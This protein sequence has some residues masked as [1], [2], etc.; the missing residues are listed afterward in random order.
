M[1]ETI[2]Q[3]DKK[4]MS[5]AISLAS[6]SGGSQQPNPRVGAVIVHQGRII[7]EGFHQ[8]AGEPHAE[9]LAV[10]S[11]QDQS[12]LAQSTIYVTLEPCFHHGRTPPCV[13]L[14][15][16]HKIPRVVIAQ[17]D[18]FEQVGGKSIA[19]LKALGHEVKLG[20]LE[21]EAAWLN[22]RFFRHIGQKR[23]YIVLKWACSLDDIMGRAG[24]NLRISNPISSRIN[25]CWR[26][27][28]SAILVGRKTAAVDNPALSNRHHFGRQPLRMVLDREGQLP[29]GLQLFDGQ[30]ATRVYRAIP[31][32]LEQKNLSFVQLPYEQ[33]LEELCADWQQLGLQSVLVEGGAQLLQ[34]FLSAGLW[35]EIRILRSSDI[36][37]QGIAA[38]I[39]PKNYLRSV[40]PLF[41]NRVEIYYRND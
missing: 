40:Q 20:V 25:H 27:Q 28:E 8:K 37:G 2:E 21:E 13:D 12:L 10:R 23:P 31:P 38:P 34:S 19:R 5:R 9:V 4:Y 30:Q 26:S 39:A 17:A 24:E 35:D 6:L 22:R 1:K 16:Q 29:M 15:V 7:G 33:L 3:L 14:I 41:D 32:A 18:P 36:L 11:V